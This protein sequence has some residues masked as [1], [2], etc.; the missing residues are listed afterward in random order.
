MREVRKGVNEV[1]EVGEG[2]SGRKGVNEVR[3]KNEGG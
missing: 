1:D 2:V 3:K